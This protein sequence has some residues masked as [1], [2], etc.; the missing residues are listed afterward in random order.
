[1]S[2]QLHQVGGDI[3]HPT[4]GVGAD[5]SDPGDGGD[6]VVG[7]GVQAP[8]DEGHALALQAALDTPALALHVALLLGV[9]VAR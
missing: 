8:R 7:V 3:G 5:H 2:R 9:P 4:H 6:L 1:M